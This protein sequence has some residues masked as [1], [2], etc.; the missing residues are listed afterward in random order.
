M[1]LEEDSI[2]YKWSADYVQLGVTRYNRDTTVQDLVRETCTSFLHQKCDASSC[3]WYQN[4][5]LAPSRAVLYSVQ[6]SGN[7]NK[8]VNY[9]CDS[10]SYCM[11]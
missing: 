5:A 8:K 3:N 11:Q 1:H 2:R 6:V 4:L 10:R 9:C 7:R